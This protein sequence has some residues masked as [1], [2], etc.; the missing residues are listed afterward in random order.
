MVTVLTARNLVLQIAKLLDD[1]QISLIRSRQVVT[2]IGP[3]GQ[4]EGEGAAVDVVALEGRLM[5]LEESVA[6]LKNALPSAP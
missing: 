5:R 1:M 4:Q 2:A 3:V 6:R